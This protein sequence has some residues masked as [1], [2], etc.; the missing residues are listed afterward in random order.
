MVIVDIQCLENICL[1]KLT[2]LLFLLFVFLYLIAYLLFYLYDYILNKGASVGA[3]EFS[4][5][6][7]LILK[8]IYPIKMSR[9][10]QP[11]W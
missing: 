8:Y 1:A 3:S 9:P 2:V 7:R 6:F 11:G 5:W 10:I 4:E